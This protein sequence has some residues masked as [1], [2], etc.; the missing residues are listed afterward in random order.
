MVESGQFIRFVKFNCKK[1]IVH[2]RN[3][4]NCESL[5]DFNPLTYGI[6]FA[7]TIIMMLKQFPH[8]FRQIKDFKKST[9]RIVNFLKIC[10]I[11]CTMTNLILHFSLYLR[12]FNQQK[13][14]GKQLSQI[15]GIFYLW[16]T[17]ST[18]KSC[19]RRK[20]VTCVIYTISRH[21]ITFLGKMFSI[22]TIKRCLFL[23]FYERYNNFKVR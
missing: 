17:I 16:S 13:M 1:K 18:Q 14:E 22:Q 23:L 11:Q 10:L 3:K 5:K 9:N 12:V 8:L 7:K 21:Q 19:G 4:L 2:E 15:I 20:F 6:S